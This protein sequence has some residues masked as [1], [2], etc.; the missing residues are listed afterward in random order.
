MLVGRVAIKRNPAPLKKRP[1]YVDVGSF[2]GEQFNRLWKTLGVDST[3]WKHWEHEQARGGSTPLVKEIPVI[4][5]LVWW[6]VDPVYLSRGD[7]EKLITECEMLV[8]QIADPIVA[9][10]LSLLSTA[11]IE[12]LQ[13]TSSD[14]N[15]GLMVV[16][17]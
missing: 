6:H 12:S 16:S 15:T 10:L 13:A 1:Q 5:K 11:G 17:A 3:R 14:D 8:G 2:D 7:V 4:S 9:T